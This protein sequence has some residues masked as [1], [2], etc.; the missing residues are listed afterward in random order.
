MG[1]Y[2]GDAPAPVTNN[3]EE[4]MREALEAQ[5]D[6]A[7]DLYSAEANE[8]YGR[9]AYARLNQRLIET[10]LLGEE[11]TVD[12]EG[13]TTR[14]KAGATP[15]GGFK[16]ENEDQMYDRYLQDNPDVAKVIASG[17]DPDGSRADWTR[18]KTAREAA[19]YH[20]D[21]F[22]VA[23]GR[24]LYSSGTYDTEG[25]AVEGAS[26]KE[27]VGGPAGTRTEGGAVEL[28]AGN[29]ETKFADG[30]TRKAGF[31]EGG[32]FMGTSQLEQ[33][34]LERA[35][36]QQTQ[37]ELSLVSDFGN[38]LTDLYRGQGGIKDALDSYN[39]LG[40][41]TSDHGGLRSGLVGMAAEELAL[42]GQLSDRERRRVEQTSREAMSA[43]G[44]GRDF[45]AVADEVAANETLSRQRE[46]E[47]R[48]FASQV[49]GLA[50]SGLAQDRAFAAQRV[51]LE[52]ATSADP[53]MAITG[54]TSGASVGS[55]QN[56]YGNAAAGVN[57]GPALFN[58]AQGAEFMANQSAMIND[59]NSNVYAADQAMTGAIMGGVFGAAGNL[60]AAKIRAGCWVAREVYG[61]HS[62]KWLMFRYWMF[63]LSPFWFRAAYL[64]FGEMFAKFIKNK[65][66][67]K[68][69][70]RGWMDKKI[71]EVV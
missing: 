10:G 67:L 55:G 43:R 39:Q 5:V 3:Y 6:M 26:Y 2:G 1:M 24:K 57:A 58:P 35:K 20:A 29:Q 60:G 27:Y 53:F 8:T 9:P 7:P 19:K 47:R 51:G 18:G 14:F 56:L 71:K 30:S 22:A 12:N 70:I 46:S 41:E 69:R 52:Q 11:F 17:R 64:N 21:K 33:D 54:K 66:R 68:A 25:N 36:R 23:D 45:M 59:Y 13:Y 32:N 15:E 65:P 42:G 28:L 62:P 50:D 38:Q 48:L 63:N 4:T 40:R 44:R 61:T 37:T 49:L 31:D 16:I 34:M